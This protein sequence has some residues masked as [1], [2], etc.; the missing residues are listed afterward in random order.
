MIALTECGGIQE[1]TFDAVDIRF[2][3]DL[4]VNCPLKIPFIDFSPFTLKY[5]EKNF[6]LF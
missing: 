1:G 6:Y 2:S 4:I 5:I 3:N